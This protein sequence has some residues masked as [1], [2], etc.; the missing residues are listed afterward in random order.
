LS[1]GGVCTVVVTYNRKNLL[2]Q[3]LASVLGQTRPPDHV[4]V[5]DNGSVDGTAALLTSEFPQVTVLKQTENLGGAG[6]F[7][8]GMKWA[9]GQGFDWIWV[10][11][12]DIEV[13]P[14]TLEYMFG[15]SNLASFIQ[16]RREG[17]DG[18][19]PIEAVLDINQCTT[20]L[21]QD[22]SFRE[23]ER[24]WIGVQFGN[25]EGGLIHRNVIRDIGYPDPRFFIAGDD[26]LY[27]Y[28]ASFHGNVIYLRKIGLRRLLP[29]PANR[30]R[31]THY[32]AVRNRFLTRAI[33]EQN[34]IPVN[35][36]IF[37]LGVLDLCLWQIK[38]ALADF[39][40]KAMQNGMAGI[41]GLRDGVRG[42]FGRPP[43]L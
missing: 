35:G 39:G 20:L 31:L 7:C 10:M 3:T 9:Y 28:L 30:N 14:E 24:E 22:R 6:G 38:E 41:A 37:W 34:H 8:V 42:R 12:D 33:L 1:G 23:S 32:L 29:L 40:P 18:L 21:L 13:L 19:V 16:V 26:T 25:F 11:D 4:L 27:G 36:K 17:P 15:Y 2:R 5:V 43:W